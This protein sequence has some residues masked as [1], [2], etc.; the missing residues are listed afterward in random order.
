VPSCSNAC[1]PRSILVGCDVWP[2]LAAGVLHCGYLLYS[3]M[4]FVVRRTQSDSSQT[5]YRQH[6]T[7]THPP[8]SPATSVRHSQKRIFSHLYK[9]VWPLLL[10]LLC[11]I[12]PK[13][14]NLPRPLK[15]VFAAIHTV[16]RTVPLS[17]SREAR[18]PPFRQRQHS[19]TK[20]LHRGCS[21][22]KEICYWGL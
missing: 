13:K 16:L 18:A 6:L 11:A 9:V 17:I 12:P 14:L 5:Q 22:N 3:R 7:E 19:Q 4:R 20:G 21:R 1:L 15:A 10:I 8:N 2:L